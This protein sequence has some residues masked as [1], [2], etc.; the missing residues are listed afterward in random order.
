VDRV[1][2]YPGH[3]FDDRGSDGVGRRRQL[4]V[5]FPFTNQISEPDVPHISLIISDIVSVLVLRLTA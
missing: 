5:G 3:V 4:I 1:F 2:A